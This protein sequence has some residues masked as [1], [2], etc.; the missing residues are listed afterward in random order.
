MEILNKK[1][2]IQYENGNS[3]IKEYHDIGDGQKL[4]IDGSFRPEW[5]A[6]CVANVVESGI[7]GIKKG[8]K[9][10]VDYRVMFRYKL[11]GETRIYDNEISLPD[12]R[13]VFVCDN[14]F[15]IAVWRNDE[16][17]AQGKWCLIKEHLPQDEVKD[18]IIISS[19]AQELALKW[20]EGDF[21]SGDL[22][23]VKGDV[24]MIERQY[25]NIYEVG[26]K[27]EYIVVENAYIV[28]KKQ[29]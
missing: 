7:E 4:Y 12:G 2:F 27:D 14:D 19:V 13:D 10:M 28:I 1:L 26:W 21:I 24:V 9:V 18:G 22:D 15:V 11:V 8:E 6:K 5:H 3:A 20:V 17:Q 23:A 29:K 16:W 25:R